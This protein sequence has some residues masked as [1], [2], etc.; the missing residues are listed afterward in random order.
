MN[1]IIKYTKASLR[2]LKKYKKKN[3]QEYKTLLNDIQKIEEN[4]YLSENI[5]IQGSKCPRCKRMKSGN[6]RIIYYVHK[7]KQT[8]EIVRII[9]RKKEYRE[10][11]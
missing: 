1:H 7:K 2:D 3:L 10:F 9:E 8:V 4:P 11:K 6:Y 5:T